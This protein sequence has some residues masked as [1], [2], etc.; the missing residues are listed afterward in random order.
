[1]KREIQNTLQDG[2]ICKSFAF[3]LE[4]SSQ[5][6][7]AAKPSPTNAANWL[8]ANDRGRWFNADMIREYWCGKRGR[9]RSVGRLRRRS[10][11]ALSWPITGWTEGPTWSALTCI[12][13]RAANVCVMDALPKSDWARKTRYNATW[14][15]DA[16]KGWSCAREAQIDQRLKAERKFLTVEGALSQR[17]NSGIWSARIFKDEY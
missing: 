11:T 2:E 7:R 16:G 12:Q 10:N 5:R 15:A 13:R 17:S 6:R 1:M 14:A 8:S 4:R 3:N 9:R